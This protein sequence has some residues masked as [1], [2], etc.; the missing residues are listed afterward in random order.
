MK[1]ES[2]NFLMICWYKTPPK[3]VVFYL[4]SLLLF[5]YFLLR[6]NTLSSPI[7]PLNMAAHP[8]CFPSPQESPNGAYLPLHPE[9]R[10]APY[11]APLGLT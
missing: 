6:L 9:I 5:L 3:M 2:H 10:Q 4:L 7:H 1:K 8:S 11:L